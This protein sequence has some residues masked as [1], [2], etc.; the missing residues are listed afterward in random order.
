[1][2]ADYV[3][4]C[5]PSQERILFLTVAKQPPPGRIGQFL[6]IAAAGPQNCTRKYDA[7]QYFAKMLEQRF[8][9]ILVG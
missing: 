6:K 7:I 2:A 8:S 5:I 9:A 1:M 4:S 3:A